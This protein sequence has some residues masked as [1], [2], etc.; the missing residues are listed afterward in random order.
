MWRTAPAAGISYVPDRLSAAVPILRTDGFRTP[1]FL[2]RSYF[3]SKLTLTGSLAGVPPATRSAFESFV[4]PLVDAEPLADEMFPS[5]SRMPPRPADGS[6]K[7]V[8]ARF[9][10][11]TVIFASSGVRTEF[12]SLTGPAL[13]STLKL[14]P[15][16]RSAV[17]VTGNLEASETFEAV[18]LT[19]L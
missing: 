7:P 10:E 14:P 6:R 16:G 19:L 5:R 1:V 15:P 9:R 4:V 12:V 17:T 13:P 18:T 2:T 8:E 11:L 3:V